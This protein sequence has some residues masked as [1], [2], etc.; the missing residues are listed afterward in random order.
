MLRGSV[1]GLGFLAVMAFLGLVDL[2]PAILCL[3]AALLMAFAFGAIGFAA[4]TFMKSWEDSQL[5]QLVTLPLL[6]FSTT[7]YPLSVYP[8]PLQ[9]IVQISPLYQAIYLLR[10]LVEAASFRMSIFISI[11][12]F[13]GLGSIGLLISTVRLHRAV[14]T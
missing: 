13:L 14:A 9:V 8:R 12:Y 2:I 3:T 6:L 7:F 1:Y 10:S 11:I 4:T 5:V